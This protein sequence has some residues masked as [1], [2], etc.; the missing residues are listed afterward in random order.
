MPTKDELIER[1]RELEAENAVLHLAV[2][3]L[4]H[5]LSKRKPTGPETNKQRA[6]EAKENMLKSYQAARKK[7]GMNKTEAREF[8]N[9]LEI[10]LGEFGRGRSTRWLVKH[11]KD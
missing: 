7:H 8:A 9:N 10:M 5:R 6:E 11:L 2:D 4:K 3:T 1:V